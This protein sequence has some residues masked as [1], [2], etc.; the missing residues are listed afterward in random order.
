MSVQLVS[1][2]LLAATAVIAQKGNQALLRRQIYPAKQSRQTPSSHIPEASSIT[3][4]ASQP[5][6]LNIKR[7]K[8][9][10]TIVR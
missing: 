7:S 9:V 1:S 2:D 3:I 8:A 5:G 10:Y 4:E 6:N